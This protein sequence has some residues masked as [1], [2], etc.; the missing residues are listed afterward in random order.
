VCLLN[1][2]TTLPLAKIREL[3][4]PL[5]IG[6]NFPDWIIFFRLSLENKKI[7]ECFS[8]THIEKMRRVKFDYRPVRV[9]NVYGD[10]TTRPELP[11]HSFG[12]ITDFSRESEAVYVLKKTIIK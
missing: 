10:D 11:W 8:R 2:S 3:K 1:S 4:A 12:P 9:L 7:L 6:E 5:M